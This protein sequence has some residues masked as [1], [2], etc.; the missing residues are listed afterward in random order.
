MDMPPRAAVPPPD[1]DAPVEKP[2]P[3]HDFLAFDF[4]RPGKGDRVAE[5][6]MPIRAEA[7]G[8]TQN[9]HGGAIATLVDLTTAIAAAR[10]TDFD[11]YAESLVTSDMHIRYLGSAR[12]EYVTGLGKVVR[13]GRQLIVVECNVVDSTERLVASADVALMRVPLR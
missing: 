9:V 13:I 3:L 12:G 1:D 2:I 4:D 7:L 5:V 6:R 11:P 8:F 10:A